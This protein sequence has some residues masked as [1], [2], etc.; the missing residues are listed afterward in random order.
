ML[1]HIELKWRK[2][3]HS[4]FWVFPFP[5]MCLTWWGWMGRQTWCQGIKE[6]HLLDFESSHQTCLDWGVLH[7]HNSLICS[8]SYCL[9]RSPPLLPVYTCYSAPVFALPTRPSGQESLFYFQAVASDLCET[10]PYS[11][12][13]SSGSTLTTS[14]TSLFMASSF[15]QPWF[16]ENFFFFWGEREGSAWTL[17]LHVKC[18]SEVTVAQLWNGLKF[19]ETFSLLLSAPNYFSSIIVNTKSRIYLHKAGE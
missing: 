12:L 17:I 7:P 2:V 13:S 8:H 6:S 11:I 5:E 9:W 15:P 3:N 1:S 19:G 4:K 18:S 10:R 14:H 16:Q